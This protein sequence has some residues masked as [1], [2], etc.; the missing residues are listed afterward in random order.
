MAPLRRGSTSLNGERA[1]PRQDHVA[2]EGQDRAVIIGTGAGQRG[3]AIR[4]LD[5]ATLLTAAGASHGHLAYRCFA[6]I[7]RK[8]ARVVVPE[9]RSDPPGG[10]AAGGPGA[11]QF[12]NL[13]RKVAA[14]LA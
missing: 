12:P 7:N 3:P 14:R 4:R 9:C 2:G 10:G 11:G 1:A 5:R 8:K 13:W 6:E